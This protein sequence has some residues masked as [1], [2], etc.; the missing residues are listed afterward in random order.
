[1]KPRRFIYAALLAGSLSTFAFTDAFFDISKNLEIFATLYREVNTYYVDDLD[2]SKIVRTGIDAMLKT[3]DPYTVFISE[4][5]IEDFRF[6][7]TGQYGGIGALVATRNGKI[8]ITDPYEGFAAQKNDI[9]AGDVIIE[10][11]GRPIQN[12]NS[13]DVGELLKGQPN[14]PITLKIQRQGMPQPIVKTI[15]REEITVKSVLYSGVIGENV[16]YIYLEGFRLDAAKE[17]EEALITLKT[18]HQIK[19]LILD[20]RSNPGG[21]LDEAVNIAGLFLP[22]GSLVVTTKGKNKQWDK[23]YK[24]TR[25]PT[26]PAIP[27]VVLTNEFSASASEIVAGVMQDYDRGVVVGQNSFGK[28]LVQTVRPLAYN[29]QLKVTTAKYYTPSGRCIQEINYSGVRDASGKA[30]KLA[31]SLRRSFTTTHGRKVYDGKGIAPDVALSAQ[32]YSEI[33]QTLIEKY[34]IFDFATQYFIDNEKIAD[35]RSFKLSEA[36]YSNFLK[37]IADKDYAYETESEKILNKYKEKANEEKYFDDVVQQFEAMKTQLAAAKAN[38]LQTHKTEIK[39]LIE[40]EIVSR[41]YFQKGRVQNRLY[42]DNEIAQAQ[43]VLAN[44]AQ[45]KKILALD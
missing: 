44:A 22:K 33:S 25:E 37:F 4:S 29:T 30:Q 16:G 24:T 23:T 1:M 36:E 20:L 6:Q 40:E 9:R 31:D 43:K 14:T 42:A 18:K 8:L 26:D 27:L 13:D 32:N 21:S 10:I 17:V 35:A 28:G 34:L 39:K 41:Y 2:A 12:K 3:L 19:Q 5:E 11:D 7:A 15:K 45:Y 38:D